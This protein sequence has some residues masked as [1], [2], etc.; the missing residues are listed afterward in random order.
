MRDPTVAALVRLRSR[1]APDLTH[2][3]DRLQSVLA[4]RDASEDSQN[5]WCG[6]AAKQGHALDDDAIDHCT[7]LLEDGGL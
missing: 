7:M 4:F 6:R 1:S 2:T 5:E 3:Q